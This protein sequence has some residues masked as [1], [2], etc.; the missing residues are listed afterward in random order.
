MQ[1]ALLLFITFLMTCYFLE[2]QVTPRDTS[3]KIT[4]LPPVTINGDTL[5]EQQIKEVEV[6]GRPKFDT[7]RK[8]RRYSRLVRNVKKVYPYVKYITIKLEEIDENLQTINNDKEKRKYIRKVQNEM[9]EQFEDDVR[10]MTFSQ[11]RI[12][13]RLIDRE[14]GST[15]YEWLKELKG[16][17]F[18][19]FWQTV[20]RIFSSNL[21]AEFGSTKEDLYIDQIVRMI[22]AGLI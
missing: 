6:F 10:H 1:K 18:A 7:K 3:K 22:D 9:M 14:T 15:S 11:G 13:V 12:L 8:A 2:A 5:P 16:D 20:A 4:I 19:G 17:F 21:K